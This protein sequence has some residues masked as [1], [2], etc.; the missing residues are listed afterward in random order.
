MHY[1][2]TPFIPSCTKRMSLH[3]CFITYISPFISQPPVRS[4]QSYNSYHLKLT[5]TTTTFSNHCSCSITRQCNPLRGSALSSLFCMHKITDARDCLCDWQGRQGMLSMPPSEL[6]FAPLAPS[7]RQLYHWQDSN[8]RSTKDRTNTFLL[9]YLGIQTFGVFKLIWQIILVIYP[10]GLSTTIWSISFFYVFWSLCLLHPV[11][12]LGL[13]LSHLWLY[14]LF[15]ITF[16]FFTQ[17]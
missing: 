14:I 16:R 3:P 12:P 10:L 11:W 7:H 17:A 6:N 15:F 5:T 8:F 4:P 2:M 1:K 13:L 9:Y